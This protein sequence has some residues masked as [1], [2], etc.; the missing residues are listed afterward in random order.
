[1]RESSKTSSRS[2][3]NAASISRYGLTSTLIFSPNHEWSFHHPDGDHDIRILR[4]NTHPAPFY[5][6]EPRQQI[7]KFF[8]LTNI[9]RSIAFSLLLHSMRRWSYL[10]LALFLASPAWSLFLLCALYLLSFVRRS[11]LSVRLLPNFFN[12]V[13]LLSFNLSSLNLFM[14]LCSIEILRFHWLRQGWW[15]RGG[16]EWAQRKR[17]GWPQNQHR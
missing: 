16:K 11:F 5:P 14:T 12:Q 10:W 17:H 6:N 3:V 2:T 13:L 9:Q 4:S 1:M 7:S 15:C 8:T